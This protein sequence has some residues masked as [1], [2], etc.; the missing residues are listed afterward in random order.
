ME[1]QE[2][3]PGHPSPP[4]HHHHQRQGE[5]HPV[6]IRTN[7]LLLRQDRDFS[8]L[9][10]D[11]N[12]VHVCE[13]LQSYPQTLMIILH[14]DN[15]TILPGPPP[16][17]TLE[18][19]EGPPGAPSIEQPP[20]TSAPLRDNPWARFRVF[21]AFERAARMEL[22]DAD[23]DEAASLEGIVFDGEDTV[24]APKLLPETLLHKSFEITLVHEERDDDPNSS[25][26][27]HLWAASFPSREQ[28]YT[29]H[30]IKSALLH[31]DFTSAAPSQESPFHPSPPPLPVA[32]FLL[33]ALLHGARAASR[34]L[35][36][37]GA[38]TNE[39]LL[40]AGGEG[41]W[42]AP[43]W[44]APHPTSPATSP[45]P[46]L[47]VFPSLAAPL[48]PACLLALP[49]GEVALSLPTPC[50][51]RLMATRA[52]LSAAD[53]L[54]TLTAADPRPSLDET[55]ASLAAAIRG[56]R[57]I[58]HDTHPADASPFGPD[59][60]PTPREFEVLGVLCPCREDHGGWILRCAAVTGGGRNEARPEV[61]AGLHHPDV[62][63]FPAEACD[64]V[65]FRPMDGGG[66]AL[67]GAFEVMEDGGLGGWM[68]AVVGNKEGGRRW[69]ANRFLGA[70]GVHVLPN[71]ASFDAHA[72]PK[73]AKT[74]LTTPTAFTHQTPPHIDRGHSATPLRATE[75]TLTPHHP[76]RFVS[77]WAVLN[78]DAD[79]TPDTDVELFCRELSRVAAR[80]GV[81]LP[82]A[83]F[84]AI[85][86]PGL[87]APPGVTHR[88]IPG[89]AGMGAAGKRAKEVSVPEGV[90][91]G[92][93]PRRVH[94]S[95]VEVEQAT[96]EHGEGDTEEGE[97]EPEPGQVDPLP[98]L[99]SQLAGS[100]DLVLLVPPTHPP[101][102]DTT[103]LSWLPASDLHASVLRVPPG[104]IR[105][106]AA[107]ARGG[108]M[109]DVEGFMDFVGRKVGE[110]CAGEDEGEVGGGEE[111]EVVVVGVVGE[112]LP[113]LPTMEETA[114]EAEQVGVLAV[115]VSTDSTL[116][117]YLTKVRHLHSTALHPTQATHPHHHPPPLFGL[118]DALHTLLTTRRATRPR[119][120][121]RLLLLRWWDE[122]AGSTGVVGATAAGKA[123]WTDT[124]DAELGQVRHAC[125][126][127]D[128]AWR[129]RVT[130]V[131][132][133]RCGVAARE[134]GVY[135]A[136]GEV[137]V[138]AGGELVARGVAEFM[139]LPP[140]TAAVPVVMALDPG[141]KPGVG[142]RLRPLVHGVVV[143]DENG[144]EVEAVAGWV[145]ALCEGEREEGRGGEW[146]PVPVRVAM[147]AV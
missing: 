13:Y 16:P 34:I 101:T 122:G 43:A 51:P 11:S 111:E 145:A 95:A 61:A 50:R 27:A 3:Q 136:S 40:L 96:Q 32:A 106:A 91:S 119:L 134:E 99:R 7:L 64:V 88:D 60:L 135:D 129:P 66:E 83:P 147:G 73:R 98:Y 92:P 65:P 18:R 67:A 140:A 54:A 26:F 69:G 38:P 42:A 37:R 80:H 46:S 89:L 68:T 97:S 4:R 94:V 36:I 114:G 143:H 100:E 141:V 53:V 121:D 55:A 115:S 15:L 133:G 70:Y 116:T 5:D 29:V 74:D 72:V 23:P 63:H 112:V 21:N 113:D 137:V 103:K 28:T 41:A 52:G 139:I 85:L 87:D 6:S 146:V 102:D 110:R 138:V 59:P 30:L 62:R 45:S 86:G 57:V 8:A 105:E 109:G 127:M 2:L 10:R 124:V 144:V 93:G 22:E 142:A 76:S 118:R 9:Q 58:L 126:K 81:N 19:A 1:G 17:T 117:R 39:T 49:N 132:V 24:Y 90:T 128:A 31:L 35:D 71:L 104:R 25:M 48:T 78:L 77:R 84:P 44:S 56:L 12:Q 82:L 123:A 125:E 131:V 20:S 130:V 120:P 107:R 14:K 75:V 79:S 47:G 108:R 33:A